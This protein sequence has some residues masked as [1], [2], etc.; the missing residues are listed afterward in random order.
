MGDDLRPRYNALV[1]ATVKQNTTLEVLRGQVDFLKR[2]NERLN[3]ELAAAHCNA[4]LL[5]NELNRGNQDAGREVQ[6]LRELLRE[7]GIDPGE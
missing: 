7:H 6:R 2:E 4:Q 3:A 1:E 5:G